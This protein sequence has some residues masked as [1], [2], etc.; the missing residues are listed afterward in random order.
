MAQEV[1]ITHGTKV[2][3]LGFGKLDLMKYL[4]DIHGAEVTGINYLQNKWK[5]QNMD[6]MPLY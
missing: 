1:N 3:E 5:M 6:S 2:L 4:R